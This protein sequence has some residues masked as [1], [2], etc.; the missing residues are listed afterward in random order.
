[1]GVGTSVTIM[2]LS[3]VDTMIALLAM[4]LFSL[5]VAGIEGAWSL[6]LAAVWS[7]VAIGAA[8]ALV[9]IWPGLLLSARARSPRPRRV[10]RR[11]L[12]SVLLVFLAGHAGCATTVAPP[13]AFSSAPPEDVLQSLRTIG[14]IAGNLPHEATLTARTPVGKAAL[15]GAAGGAAAT[16]IGLCSGARGAAALVCPIAA[17]TL[18]PVGA[19]VGATVEALRAE[20]T[21]T[22]E[23]A[24]ALVL[25]LLTES[26]V[27]GALRDRVANLGNEW[28]RWRPWRFVILPDDGPGTPERGAPALVERG[29]ET[30]L[31]LN[32]QGIGLA[33]V[34][35]HINPPLAL[36]MTVRMR[37]LRV[38]DMGVLHED[39]LMWE[40]TPRRL[41]EWVA[42]EGDRLRQEIREA[43]RGL[44]ERIADEVFLLFPPVESLSSIDARMVRERIKFLRVGTTT[45]QEILDRLGEPARRYDDGRVLMYLLY[46]DRRGQL[47]PSP[48]PGETWVRYHLVLVFGRDDR[49][50]AH[51]LVPWDK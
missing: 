13:R 4:V 19:A 30:V 42:D 37:L 14:V 16:F 43:S 6:F 17:A 21:A 10:A 39:S 38:P 25:R 23:A 49:L 24:P 31:E 34:G 15:W 3:C 51:P 50:E 35:T 5:F 9:A 26:D 41:G 22:V 7:F 11:L 18:A 48:P 1:M 32:V 47:R 33:G 45:R 12:I 28:T 36:V 46:R 44:A 29:V 8:M 27:P 20:P 2:L 40:S